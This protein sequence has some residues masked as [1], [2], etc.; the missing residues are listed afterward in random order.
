MNNNDQAKE[1][2]KTKFESLGHRYLKIFKISRTYETHLSE[3]YWTTCKHCS[4]KCGF[5]IVNGNLQAFR[6]DDEK[7]IMTIEGTICPRLFIMQ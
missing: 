6:I 3:I 7:R 5:N 1:I 2:L 4:Y